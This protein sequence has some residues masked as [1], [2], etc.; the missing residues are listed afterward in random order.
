[1]YEKRSFQTR[2]KVYEE[3]TSRNPIHLVGRQ[4]A[5][6]DMGRDDKYSSGVVSLG[7]SPRAPESW[8]LRG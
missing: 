7:V 2:D 4:A 5:N 6:C 3:L 1:M 8:P